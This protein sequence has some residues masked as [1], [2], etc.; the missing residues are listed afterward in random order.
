MASH[1]RLPALCLLFLFLPASWG[2][3]EVNP[4]AGNK[5]LVIGIDGLRSDALMAARAPSLKALM[6]GGASTVE[7]LADSITRSGPGWTSVVSGVWHGKH[8]VSDNSFAGYRAGEYPHFFKRIKEARPDLLTASIVDWKPLNSVLLRSADLALAPGDDDS[9]AAQAAGLLTFGDPDVLFLHFD[10]V[11]HAGHGW[12]F[13]PYS[14]PYL[15]AIRQTDDRVGRV[16]AALEARP[17]RAREKWLILCVTDHGG[18]WRHHGADIPECRRIPFMVAGDGAER[19][20]ALAEA[21]LVDVA[22]T[23]LTYLGIP[24]DPA[25]GWEGRPRGLKPPEPGGFAAAPDAPGR[26]ADQY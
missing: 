3:P 19:G 8:G 22:P 20:E 6:R 15:L 7:A 13:S 17:G 24:I 10:A 9:V 4:C 26:R 21:S 25:W 1:R 11:D 2:N 12:G 16:L 18:I 14:I 5:V 23:I